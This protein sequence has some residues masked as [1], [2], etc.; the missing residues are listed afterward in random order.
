MRSSRIRRIARE[1]GPPGVL[2]AG[3]YVALREPKS[4]R[5]LIGL[6]VLLLAAAMLH[7]RS[8]PAL[9][10]SAV[11]EALSRSYDLL[12]LGAL[13]GDYFTVPTGINDSG[14]VSGISIGPNCGRH[15]VVWTSGKLRSLF[16]AGVTAFATGI[17][18][19]GDVVGVRA[20]AGRW[21]AFLFSRGQERDLGT[22]GGAFSLAR[23]VNAN[24]TVVGI[25]MNADRMPNAFIWSDGKMRR[26]DGL[27]SD[28]F[29]IGSSLNAGGDVAGGVWREND[30]FRAFL[31]HRGKLDLVPALISGGMNFATDVSDAGAV[32][33]WSDVDKD[34][35]CSHAFAWDG[36]RPRDLGTLGGEDSY[37]EA[38]NGRGQIVGE[39]Q[40]DVQ[41]FCAVLW[42]G[43][44]MTDLN[45]L[46]PQG[47][48]WRLITASG[49]NAKGQIVGF[50]ASGGHY[51]GYLLTPHKGAGQGTVTLAAPTAWPPDEHRADAD[52]FFP[53][54]SLSTDTAITFVPQGD[55][56]GL[57]TRQPATARWHAVAD[58]GGALLEGRTGVALQYWLDAPDEVSDRAE[59]PP[60]G[61][62][63]HVAILQVAPGD[64]AAHSWDY[65][66]N[67]SAYKGAML[68]FDRIGGAT[69]E[70]RPDRSTG[71]EPVTFQ[72][73]ANQ[74]DEL[75]VDRGGW[76]V[77]SKLG[78]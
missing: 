52:G 73:C 75:A 67:L 25:S 43:G 53:P 66:R 38:I 18:P 46:V 6:L 24:R 11:S 33:G 50:G 76:P 2:I 10:Q 5:V 40:N 23:A 41:D 13:P 64:P 1:W 39:A 12:D 63:F 3:L 8:R 70:G 35:R 58:G 54:R 20:R 32:I 78:L 68:F 7:G 16:P 34:G 26:P 21:R 30:G 51:H 60:T 42:S 29:S 72:D 15:A 45:S 57:R 59:P 71:F 22:L 69:D 62:I 61:G 55:V 47:A 44:K 4:R 74:C 49:I 17:G 65:G 36:S 48:R 14:S 28:D 27:E 37:A 9:Q 77:G 56:F 31:S 19:S